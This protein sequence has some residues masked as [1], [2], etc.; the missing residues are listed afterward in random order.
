MIDVHS[1]IL[2]GVDDGAL[3]P[4]PTLKRLV[5]RFLPPDAYNTIKRIAGRG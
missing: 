4:K 5:R 2:P 1:H 3:R